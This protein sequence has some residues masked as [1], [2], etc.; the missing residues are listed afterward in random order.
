MKKIHCI[1]VQSILL[2]W[3]FLNMTGLY[4]GNNCLVSRS[5]KDDGIFFLINLIVFVLFIFKERI[6]KWLAIVWFAMWFAIQFICHE[7]YTIFNGGFM[8]TL[9]GKIEYFSGTI[10]WLQIEGRYIPDVYHTI[11]HILILC[12]LISTIVYSKKI[13][14]KRNNVNS[15]FFNN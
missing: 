15:N 9:Q 3:F 12:A 10:Q 13:A 14:K 7:W 6:G 8:G 2:L 4:F 11:L 5:Y 1:I